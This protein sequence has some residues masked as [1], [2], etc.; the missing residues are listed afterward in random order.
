MTRTKP[1][2]RT[3]GSRNP[4]HQQELQLFILPGEPKAVR[5]VKLKHVSAFT[6]LVSVLCLCAFLV[7]RVGEPPAKTPG[8][9]QKVR[10]GQAAES[11][12]FLTHQRAAE[13]SRL[14]TRLRISS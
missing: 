8:H 2:K 10:R 4:A 7:G 12:V 6:M 3:V 1:R 11:G 14:R 9:E 13:S 5:G